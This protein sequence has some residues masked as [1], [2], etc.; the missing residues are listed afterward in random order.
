MANAS[1]LPGDLTVNGQVS[2]TGFYVS[3]GVITDAM[4]AAGAKVATTKL[5]HRHQKHYN[6]ESATTA[7]SEARVIHLV[8][9][10]TGSLV[11]ITAGNVVACIGAATITVDCLKN[12]S[13]ILTGV[14][15]L[16]STT[17]AYTVQLTG[18][19]TSTALVAGDVLEIKIVATAGGGTIGKGP[20][21]RLT[22]DE[23]PS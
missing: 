17:T 15:T 7:V 18:T 5:R 4:M 19:F 1:I 9:G 3:A 20:F 8:K 22:I 6:Q 16:S 10:T 21:V 23:D 13:T 11:D 2:C 12:G 14:I